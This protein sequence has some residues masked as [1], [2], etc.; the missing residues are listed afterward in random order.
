MIVIND[1]SRDNTLEIA[2]RL[3]KKYPKLKILNKKNS[4]KA[5]SLNKGLKFAKGELVAV[6]DSD[7][8]PRKDAL[9]KMVGFFEDPKVGAATCPILA[10]NKKRFFERL[11]AIEYAVIALTRKLWKELVQFM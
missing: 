9:K 11:Q 1:G 7:S 10:R 3:Q 8:F 4:G 6:V 2:K 5:D